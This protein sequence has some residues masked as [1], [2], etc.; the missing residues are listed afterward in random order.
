MKIKIQKSGLTR[1]S[2]LK[3]KL[4]R[5]SYHAFVG[6]FIGIATSTALAVM[7][8]T[9]GLSGVVVIAVAVA[10]TL[11]KLNRDVPCSEYSIC[12]TAHPMVWIDAF[13]VTALV[14][15]GLTIGIAVAI[16]NWSNTSAAK[17]IGSAFPYALALTAL[18][19]LPLYA[20]FLR[21]YS[22]HKRAMTAWLSSTSDEEER[23]RRIGYFRHHFPT[24]LFT[25][26]G[27]MYVATSHGHPSHD[28]FQW[29][30]VQTSSNDC[31]FDDFSS[32]TSSYYN[33]ASGLPMAGD[34]ECGVDVAGNP[35]GTNSSSHHWD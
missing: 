30:D 26:S 27:P 16:A 33:P 29:Q 5:S 34:C 11:F 31:D 19:L 9:S 18:V 13:K 17:A 3:H 10:Y 7:E 4:L 6:L 12:A 32:S 22:E 20:R 15:G 2:H 21:Q 28:M 35:Y 8:L 1:K 23:H 25:W 24:G 14:C